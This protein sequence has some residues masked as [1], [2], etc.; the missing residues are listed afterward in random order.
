M[1]ELLKKAINTEG[2]IKP[3][4]LAIH[5]GFLEEIKKLM[6]FKILLK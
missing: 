1:H 2:F 6:V 3:E 5:L 4:N